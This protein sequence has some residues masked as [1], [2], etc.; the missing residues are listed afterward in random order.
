ML[1]RSDSE[2]LTMQ[3][4]GT[5]LGLSREKEL[6]NS[7]RPHYAHFFAAMAQLDRSTFVRPAAKL[8]TVKV[9]VSCSASHFI[10]FSST[11]QA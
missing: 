1:K 8:W 7:F 3:V 4:V 11:F 9:H 5:T 6:L 2:V 10:C